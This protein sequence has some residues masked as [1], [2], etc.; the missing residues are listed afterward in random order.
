MDSILPP[1]SARW[2]T[3]RDIFLR[4]MIPRHLKRNFRQLNPDA[5]RSLFESLINYG[6]LSSDKNASNDHIAKICTSDLMLGR[7]EYCRLSTIP[8]LDYA[9][10]LEGQRI[11][12]IGCGTGCS[13]VAMGEQGA[14]VT[15][16]DIREDCLAMAK[17]RCEIYGLD[18]AFQQANANEAHHVFSG[19][20]FDIILFYATLEHMT[21]DER[22]TVLANTWDMLKPGGFLCVAET[23]NRLWMVDSHT[24]SL[25]FFHWLPDELALKYAKYSPEKGLREISQMDTPD[26]LLNFLRRGR[27]VSFHEFHLAIGP[28]EKL[29]VVISLQ[30][31][32]Q[33]RSL[34][35]RFARKT[36]LQYR[37]AR[38]LRKVGPDIHPGF[39]ERG[40]YLVIRKQ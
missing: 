23:P 17:E 29:Q 3:C 35:Y 37:F 10:R 32:T 39:Y 24:S 31:L 30:E 20:E 40:L 5:L 26:T 4:S 15:G 33:Q 27:G 14:H 11:L 36:T 12:E 38:L 16:I 7:L 6:L 21:I 1:N 34:L 2:K 25:P 19:Q 22:L 9:V 8:L 28:I 13:S 18:A